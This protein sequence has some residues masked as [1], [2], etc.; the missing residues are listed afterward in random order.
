M[1]VTLLSAAS[2]GEVWVVRLLS[3]FSLTGLLALLYR[4]GSRLFEERVPGLLMASALLAVPGSLTLGGLAYGA[5]P[6]F[7]LVVSAAVLWSRAPVGSRI[8]WV[9]IRAKARKMSL[10]AN[11]RPNCNV[12]KT[13]TSLHRACA[14]GRSST[15]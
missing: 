10:L 5:V 9:G 8:R 3:V 11:R 4:W 7:L 1:V 14:H 13:G 15:Q 12:G 2:G 6:A